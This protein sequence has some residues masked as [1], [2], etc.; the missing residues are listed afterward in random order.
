MTIMTSRFATIPT[1]ELVLPSTKE[2]IKYRPY[3]V[4]EEK[5]LLMA[6]QSKNER[7]LQQALGDIVSACT[8]GLV[9][10]DVNPMFDI[11]YVFLKIRCKSVGE[12][13][14][15]SLTCMDPE[16]NHSQPHVVDLDK[17]EVT[18]LREHSGVVQVGNVKVKLRYP[19]VETLI[20]IKESEDAMKFFVQW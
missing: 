6:M 11:Q 1:Y 17:I 18:T 12:F 7:E 10:I 19:T 20:K 9:D 13:S 5:L 3:V 8:F 14:E 2:T 4:K 16:C 15:V